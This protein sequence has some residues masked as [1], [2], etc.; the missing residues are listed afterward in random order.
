MT[1][2]EFQ[3]LF[4]V[5]YDVDEEIFEFSPVENWH[6]HNIDLFLKPGRKTSCLIID[7][8]ESVEEAQERVKELEQVREESG[9]KSLSL[10][11]EIARVN[12]EN[13]TLEE[14]RDELARKERIGQ[15]NAARLSRSYDE[16]DKLKREIAELKGKPLPAE[17]EW[18][19]APEPPDVE[20]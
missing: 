2:D 16:N 19:E 6:K 17:G 10:E 3:N 7:V 1:K 12:E 8:C 18:P 15:V 13:K 14:V 4:Y 20:P 5:L 11:E 9:K